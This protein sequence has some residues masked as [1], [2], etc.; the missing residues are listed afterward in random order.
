MDADGGRRRG[1]CI[2]VRVGGFPGA[3][4]A[5]GRLRQLIGH[6]LSVKSKEPSRQC[7][8]IRS[9]NAALTSVCGIHVLAR[10]PC[11]S[12][13]LPRYNTDLGRHGRGGVSLNYSDSLTERGSKILHST[14]HV[15]VGF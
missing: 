10:T 6:K 11:S 5:Q 4:R 7:I 9:D 13:K 2:A 8:A 3:E 12:L 15:K 14:S 1:T